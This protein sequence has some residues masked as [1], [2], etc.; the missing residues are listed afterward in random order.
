MHRILSAMA[1]LLLAS[2]TPVTGRA[3]ALLK[4]LVVRLTRPPDIKAETG[5]RAKLLVPPGQLYDPLMLLLVGEAVWLNDDGGEEHDKGSRLLALDRRGGITVLAGLGKLM[6]TVGFDLA[7]AGFG[8]YAG[9]VFSLAQPKVAEPGALANHIVQRSEPARGFATSVFC[10]LPD[11]GQKK[12]PGF[13]LDAHFGPSGSPFANRLFVVTIYNDA[14]Y[15]VKA[16]GTCTPFV[17]FD[18]KQYSAPSM[19]TFTADGQ[20]MLVTVSI[21]AFDITSKSQSEGAILRIAPDGKVAAQPLYRGPGK[22]MGMDFAPPG[23]GAFGGQLFFAEIGQFQIP[24][25]M[26]QPLLAD[27]KVYRLTPAGKA[28]WVASGLVNPIGLRFVRDQLWVS[29]INGDFI[30]GRRELPDGFVVVME[31]K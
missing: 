6:P 12:I 3:E 7:P 4:D 20:T 27:G 16:D 11:A 2:A 28:I 29:D 31:A 26:T 24:V 25:P 15:Q 18:G 14:I 5:F 9:Q 22:P 23:F 19:L 17:V 13:G 10:T 8:A 21:G 30:T 1:V